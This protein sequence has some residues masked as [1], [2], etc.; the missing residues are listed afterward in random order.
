MIKDILVHIDNSAEC[1]H[2]IKA[3]IQIASLHQAHLTGVFVVY[4]PYMPVYAE[5]QFGGELLEENRRVMLEY[6]QE[7][8]GYFEKQVRKA[9]IPWEWS[10]REGDLATTLAE[11]ARYY[12]L[13][14]LGQTNP[15]NEYLGSDYIHDVVFESALP[16]L[17]VPYVGF[18]HAI[19]KRVLVSWNASREAARALKDSLPLLQHAEQIEVLSIDP[20]RN[21]VNEGDVPGMDISKHL[22][23][24]DLKVENHVC[25]SDSASIGDTLLSRVTDFDTD[26]IVMGAYGHSRLRETILGG[27]TRHLLHHMTVPVFMSH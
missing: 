25:Y 2:R 21:L 6:A 7:A 14:V 17:I 3:A 16:C 23:R 24:H 22:A 26:M 1:K 20:K 19:G 8:R 13:L 5:V 10:L 12:D 18:D 11:H 9:D 4:T 27:V 15:D